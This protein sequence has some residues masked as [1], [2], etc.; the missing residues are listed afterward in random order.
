MVKGKRADNPLR[1]RGV[2][3][4]SGAHARLSSL[5]SRR[6]EE[7]SEPDAELVALAKAREEGRVHPP[8]PAEP[9]SAIEALEHRLHELEQELEA[10]RE[11]LRQKQLELGSLRSPDH[12]SSRSLRIPANPL[13]AEATEQDVPPLPP[14]PRS[15]LPDASGPD[16]GEWQPASALSVGYPVLQHV[17]VALRASTLPPAGPDSA[18]PS[19]RKAPRRS[20]EIEL[21]F[22]EETQFYTGLTQDI[23]EGGVFVATYRLF[24][25]GTRLELSFQLPDGTL[26]ST[27][28]RVRWLRDASAENRPGMGVEFGELRDDVARAIAR[29]CEQRAPL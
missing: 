12:S 4:E 21:A 7:F 2:T 1:P 17:A 29:F 23:S 5:G 8:P 24:P 14:P 13:P 18:P 28:G 15:L 9:E 16:S 26:V 22:T 27:W 10:T 3:T 20:C 19:Q 25:I 6:A 11:S